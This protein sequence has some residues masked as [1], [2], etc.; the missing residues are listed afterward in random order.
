M[1]DSSDTNRR[2]ALI[3]KPKR[4]ILKQQPLISN[5]TNDELVSILEHNSTIHTL[6]DDT[7]DNNE[8]CVISKAIT[9]N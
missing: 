4:P 5:T 7:L 6:Q 9:A 1:I 2:K 8:S 3:P